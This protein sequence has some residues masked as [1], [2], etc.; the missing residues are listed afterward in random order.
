MTFSITEIIMGVLTLVAGV[1][2]VM[3]KSANSQK[4][5]AETERDNVVNEL[6]RQE[7]EA[8]IQNEI[9]K[10]KNSVSAKSD[11]DIDNSLLSDARDR[12]SDAN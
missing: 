1:L 8:G 10:A 6:K 7:K 4:E 2:G 12:D 3:W 11:S 9:D 5:L